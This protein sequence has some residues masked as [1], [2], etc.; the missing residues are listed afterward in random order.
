MQETTSSTIAEP[1]A[2]STSQIGG[3]ST[4]SSQSL[5]EH[6][7]KCF[8]N[9]PPSSSS[10]SPASMMSAIWASTSTPV[11][12]ATGSETSASGTTS[13]PQARRAQDQGDRDIRR[14]RR[15]G[16]PV[17]QRR[18]K[19]SRSDLMATA[20]DP[21]QQDDAEERFQQLIYAP[22]AWASKQ[23]RVRLWNEVARAMCIEP[24]PMT[25]LKVMKF[26]ACLR[27]AGYRSGIT[28]IHEAIQ[29]HARLG[30][31]V[32]ESLRVAV[33]D[34]KRGLQRGLGGPTRSAEIRPEWLDRLH[35]LV[36]SGERR[37]HRRPDQPRGGLHVWGVGIGWLLREV[38]LA[39]LDLHADTLK[40][41][42]VAGTATLR[43]GVSK[44]DPAGR[45]A[46]RTFA[47]RCSRRRL[48]SCPACSAA[49]LLEIAV[50]NWDGDRASDE[51]RRVPLIGTIGS[52]GAVVA[53]A[54]MV[55]AAQSDAAQLCELGLLTASP[56]EVTGHFLRRSGA[57]ALAR[58]GVPLAKIQW[59]GRWGSAAV[60]AYVEEAA[61]E[62]PATAEQ[63]GSAGSAV[64]WEDLRNDLAHALRCAGPEAR[65][66]RREGMRAELGEERLAAVESFLTTIRTEVGD[67]GSLY[68]ELDAMVRPPFVLNVSAKSVHRTSRTERLNPDLCAT[69]CGWYWARSSNARPCSAE[70]VDR[71]GQLWSR[72]VRCFPHAEA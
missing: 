64:Q 10:S 39:M 15:D 4:V 30:H 52:A 58:T 1:L 7:G 14:Q 71:A 53:K 25:P 69:P 29:Q 22:A 16:P 57:K 66:L 35:G 18:E 6:L 63:V 38:E 48:P 33:A 27:D 12:L 36:E 70:D 23:T 54:S 13:L 49:V 31:H 60:M 51:A 68:R 45:G 28:Y 72:C 65:E 59:L 55:Q 24:Y 50:E 37:L 42:V 21:T 5:S 19:G 44:T 47:C 9:C 61:E 41:D 32:D 34:A 43:I 11:T 56:D 46:A 17:Q 3:T 20:S 2:R 62:A 40:V 67:L 26:S 8:T